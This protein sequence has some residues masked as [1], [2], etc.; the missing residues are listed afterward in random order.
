MLKPQRIIPLNNQMD[1]FSKLETK[2]FLLYTS[3]WFTALV[4][5]IVL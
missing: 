1:L 4:L 5:T 3:G 2:P